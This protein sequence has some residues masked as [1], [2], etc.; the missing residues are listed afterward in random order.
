MSIVDGDG[1]GR[2]ECCQRDASDSAERRH[3]TSASGGGRGGGNVY[4]DALA[5]R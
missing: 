1:C 4:A 5:I 2:Q 3:Y